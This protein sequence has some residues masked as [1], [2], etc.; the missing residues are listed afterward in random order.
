M[1]FTGPIIMRV[2]SST[3]A[4]QQKQHQRL[5]AKKLAA[6]GYLLLQLLATRI[7]DRPG[8][9]HHIAVITGENFQSGGCPGIGSAIFTLQLRQIADILTQRL[10]ELLIRQ[11]AGVGVQ[12]L[13]VALPLVLID[14][15][16]RRIVQHAVLA[17]AALHL[18]CGIDHRLLRRASTVV[19]RLIC[20]ARALRA[21]RL[22]QPA[23]P[24]PAMAAGSAQKRASP[25]DAANGGKER[26]ASRM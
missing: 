6:F 20:A 13:A 21:F 22:C 11:H 19:V 8:R 3:S 16:Q 9:L 12:H 10:P 15:R 2:K 24:A 17:I 7:D 14:A 23:V 1:P 25:A 5:P 18:Q 26:V 4:A